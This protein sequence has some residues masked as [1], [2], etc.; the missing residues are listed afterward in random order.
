MWYDCIYIRCTILVIW[1]NYQGWRL[2][3]I[4]GN[5]FALSGILSEKGNVEVEDS[6]GG[7][8]GRAE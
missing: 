2:Q 4:S 8:R 7:S 3:E 6:R 1:L 5:A